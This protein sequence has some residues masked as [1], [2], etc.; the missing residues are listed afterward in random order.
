MA[1]RTERVVAYVTPARKQQLDKLCE[2][3]DTSVSAFIN[4]AIRL[5]LLRLDLDAGDES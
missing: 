3:K 1:E 2:Q 5:C 4:E